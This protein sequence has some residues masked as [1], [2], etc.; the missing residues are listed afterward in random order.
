MVNMPKRH[1]EGRT[2]EDRAQARKQLG[3]LKQ[4]TVQPVTRARYGKARTEFYEW[5]S[6]ENLG[7][8]TTAYHLDMV[9]S[10]YLEYL[11]AAGKGRTF[12]SNILAA[13][14]DHQPHLKGRLKQSWR[15]MKT[16]V[17]NELPSRAPP[18]SLDV[19]HLLTGYA[20]FKN[21]HLFALSLLLAF[22]GL[23][24][25]GELLSL[26]AKHV[27]VDSPKGL[28]VLSLGLTK[29]GKR[30]GAAESVTIHA[31]DVCRGLFQWKQHAN[32]H[33]LLTGSGYAWR[34]QFSAIMTAVGLA[35]FEYRPY[36]LRRGGRRSLLPIAWQV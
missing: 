2:E 19:L 22:H 26:R 24:R 32:S 10:D 3:T 4:L 35:K 23:L 11:W 36:S 20:L 15:L 27:S 6:N 31:E 12:A 34:K 9:V 13:L 30:H 33:D 21:L 8:P 14:L 28:A 18:F 17:T 7:M 1:L 16:W 5:L 25:A 29:S